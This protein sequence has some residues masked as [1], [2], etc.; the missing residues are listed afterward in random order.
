MTNPRWAY[1]AISKDVDIVVMS[2]I[3]IRNS[4]GPRIE[5]FKS[6]EGQMYSYLRQQFV[7]GFVGSF[8]ITSNAI[9]RIP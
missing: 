8:P 6:L 4:I 2:L 5:H 3:Y 1:M 7:V 9:L